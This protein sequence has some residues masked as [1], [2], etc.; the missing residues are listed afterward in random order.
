MTKRYTLLVICMMMVTIGIFAQDAIPTETVQQTRV[1]HE[2]VQFSFDSSLAES[3]AFVQQPAEIDGPAPYPAYTQYLLQDYA[4]ETPFAPG[5]QIN[6]L[7]T[8]NFAELPVYGDQLNA[9]Y[10]LLAERPELSDYVTAAPGTPEVATL[11]FLPVYPAAQVFR[12]QPEYLEMPGLS[13]VRYLVYFSQGVNPIVEGNVFYTFQGITDDGQY[14]VSIIFPV[15]TGVLSIDGNVEDYDAF[16]T[17]YL[18][19]LDEVVQRVHTA[20][21]F[22]PA[23]STLDDVVQSIRVNR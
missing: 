5:A 3:V 12:A 10:L 17:N 23:L 9:L 4:Y 14:F 19:Y 20:E 7:S 15:N 8:S 6:I 16:A 22:S 1:N 21:F 18:P 11:P 2:G 13:G